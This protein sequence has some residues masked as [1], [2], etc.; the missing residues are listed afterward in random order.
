MVTLRQT[1]V[2]AGAL[3]VGCAHGPK[4]AQERTALEQDAMAALDRMTQQDPGIRQ[5]LDQAAGYVVFPSIKQGGFIVGGAGG[6]GVVFQHGTPIGFAEMSRASVGAE[7]GGQKF[8][9]L[10]VLRDQS[11]LDRLRAS[12]F[13]IGGQASA[14]M[15]RSGAAAST[16]FSANGVSVFVDPLGGA[17]INVSLMGQRVRFTS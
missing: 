6:K 15:I 16:Q 5:L 4:N 12:P 17:M 1:L 9:E 2:L 11:A 13:D 8:A 7:V 14:V 3:A 10:I